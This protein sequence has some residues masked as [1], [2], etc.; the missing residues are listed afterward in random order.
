MYKT[1]SL[2]KDPQALEHKMIWDLTGH[3]SIRDIVFG[4][5]ND[6]NSI[7]SLGI[8]KDKPVAFITYNSFLPDY[9]KFDVDMLEGYKYLTIAEA[10][11][12]ND[13]LKRYQDLVLN[14]YN[15]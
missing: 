9:Q 14:E 1:Y 12:L 11:Y 2:Q 13:W 10:E 15:V 7:L 5:D 6:N 8:D 3:T 4:T